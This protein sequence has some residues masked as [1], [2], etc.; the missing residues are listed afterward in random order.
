EE[1]HRSPTWLKP[2]LNTEACEPSPGARDLCVH[3]HRVELGLDEAEPAKASCPL[4]GVAGEQEA[5][6]ELRQRDDA[7]RRLV[8]QQVRI[9]TDQDGGVED[10][11]HG[12]KGSTRSPPRRRRS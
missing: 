6:V 1:V 5:E 12:E 10:R 8:R 4:G 2:T 11:P 7:D 9:V 3:R